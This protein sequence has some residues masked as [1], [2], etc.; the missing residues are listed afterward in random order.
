MSRP[1]VLRLSNRILKNLITF[2]TNQGNR[3]KRRSESMKEYIQS[4]N[5]D[6]DVW[7]KKV[8]GKQNRLNELSSSHKQTK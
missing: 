7:C 2:L 1:K 8:W 4:N 5:K 3:W 6:G